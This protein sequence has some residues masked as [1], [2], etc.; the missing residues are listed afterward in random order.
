MRFQDAAKRFAAAVIA[1]GLLATAALA[2][3]PTDPIPPVFALPELSSDVAGAA[4][5]IWHCPW[6]EAGAE[7]DTVI[8]LASI[9]SADAII[10]IPNPSPTDEADQAE[11]RLG[12]LGA[13]DIELGDVV[14]RGQAP[15]FV[16]FDGG[17]AM[18]ST[19]MRSNTLLSGDRCVASAPKI[20]YLTGGTTRSGMQLTLRLFNPFPENSRVNVSGSSEFGNE[21]LPGGSLDV[22]ARSWRDILLSQEVPFL[23]EL[24]LTVS[25]ETGLVLPMMILANGTDEAT[26]PGT[27]LSEKWFFPIGGVEGV[28]SELIVTNPGEAPVTLDIEVFTS[29]GPVPGTSLTLEPGGPRRIQLNELAAGAFG[30]EVTSSG[31][32]AA[33]VVAAEAVSE[34]D[35][36]GGEGEAAPDESG[37]LGGKLAGTVGRNSPA[38]QW[39]VAGT[40]NVSITATVWLM[41][42]GDQP[43]TVTLQPLGGASQASDKISIG[44]GQLVRYPA[45]DGLGYFIESTQPISV[46]W[47]ASSALGLAFIAGVAIE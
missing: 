21:P 34:E 44:D 7:R 19:L 42:S 31:P 10:T 43:A 35:P 41:N 45:R 26:W 5:S 25:S 18:V 30:I 8:S 46:S 12:A 11:L 29:E 37:P 17:P 32:T 9:G 40:G 36:G 3:P 47:S 15:M 2:A 13:S 23:D 38:T 33:V 28:E 4:Q 20:W 6:A 39:M 14:R 16:E 22:P 27:A 1:A 24:S